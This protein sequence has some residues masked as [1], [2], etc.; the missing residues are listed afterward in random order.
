MLFGD[1]PEVTIMVDLAVFVISVSIGLTAGTALIENIRRCQCRSVKDGGAL[2][3]EYG[4]ITLVASLV[5][6]V[7][8][9]LGQ[10]SADGV[11]QTCESVAIASRGDTATQYDRNR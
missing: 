9:L 11:S 2:S 8:F 7:I 6:G 1:W 10:L 5:V 4:L 3:V